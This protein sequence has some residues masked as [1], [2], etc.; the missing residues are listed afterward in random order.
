MNHDIKIML[1]A[2]GTGSA[3]ADQ[4]DAMAQGTGFDRPI[5]IAHRGASGYRPEHT[6]EAYTHGILQGADFIEPDLVPTGDGHLIARHENALA[7]VTLDASGNIV[8]DGLG[9][10]I[11]TSETTNVAHLPQFA[12]RLAVKAID[13]VRIGGWFSEDFTLSEIRTMRCRERIPGVRPANASFN[14]QF[15][16]PTFDDVILL[17][18]IVE[19]LTGREIGIYPETKHP[20]YFEYEGRRLDTTPI[21]IDTSRLLVEALVR[22]GFTDPERVFIQSFEFQNLIELQQVQMPAAGIDMPLVQLYGDVAECCV[23]P[24]D[25]FSRPY[26]M[27]YNASIGANLSAIYGPLVGAVRNGITT[28]THY[29]DILSLRA[30]MTMRNLYAEGIGPWK[31]SFLLRV[32]LPMPVD[33]NGDGL[34]Q[35]TSGL[36]GQVD[37]FLGYAKRVG[38][39]VHPYTLRAEENFLTVHANGVPQSVTGEVL[40]LLALGVDGFFIDQPDLGVAG[41]DLF[42]TAN[43]HDTSDFAGGANHGVDEGQVLAAFQAARC[44]LDSNDC[45]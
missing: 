31:N 8:L 35:I 18:R 45:K 28:N 14:D 3:F 16:V 32:P 24:F 43:G 6:I 33:G 25:S 19:L 36:N 15:L 17:V 2:L 4:S 29:G 40:H 38:L 37:P 23:Q 42:L 44:A 12:G 21:C 1:L 34:A 26:D 10:P 39:K 20:T 13:G 11:L 30:L 5:V 9:N 41:R 27:Y 7:T 22:N